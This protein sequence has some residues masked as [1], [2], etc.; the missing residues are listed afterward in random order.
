MWGC[1]RDDDWNRASQIE[2][3]E[4]NIYEWQTDT[5]TDLYGVVSWIN[6]GPTPISEVWIIYYVQGPKGRSESM[7]PER[8][9]LSLDSP[10]E[11][12]GRFDPRD[13]TR[14]GVR[15]GRKDDL[16]ERYGEPLEF[17]VR[18]TTALV[19]RSTPPEAE[20]P[21]PSTAPPADNETGDGENDEADA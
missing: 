17:R 21:A 14:H 18:F 11:A 15:L 6:Q 19:D 2:P 4:T 13:V 5:G 16:I 20:Q 1:Y 10:V 3:V 7:S 8:P 12:K 9:F